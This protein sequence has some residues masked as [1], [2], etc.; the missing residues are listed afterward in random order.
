MSNRALLVIAIC[1]CH[2]PAK[3][4]PPPAVTIRRTQPVIGERFVYALHDRLTL[5]ITDG[6][7]TLAAT[8]ENDT[9]A[10]EI[11]EAVQN[12]VAM[13]R[14]VRFITFRHKPLA[15]ETPL[16]APVVGKTYRVR[17]EGGTRVFDGELTAAERTALE[18][19]VRPDT[20]QPDLPTELL[21][22]RDFTRGV[23]WNIPADQPAPFVR[24]VHHGASITL[25]AID[26]SL[27]RFAITQQIVVADVPLA[28]NGTVV[29]DI[30]TARIQSI[31][32]EGHIAQPTGKV[33]EARLES[34]QTFTYPR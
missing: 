29:M 21:T 12:G 10:E 9:E 5:A 34:H 4:V 7:T 20:G 24:G 8:E 23:A 15:S 33:V 22:E 2:R 13:Q 31:D 28:L 27:A 3:P 18:A 11:I 32:L 26:G 17:A 25:T 6:T 14:S 16:D 19:Y 1:A 30:A